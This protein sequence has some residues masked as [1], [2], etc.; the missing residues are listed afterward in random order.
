MCVLFVYLFAYGASAGEGGGSDWIIVK[1]I[2]EE[3]VVFSKSF[4][5]VERRE[6][7]FGKVI[8]MSPQPRE[9]QTKIDE[10]INLIKVAD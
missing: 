10:I 3:S 6:T 2:I 7:S 5:F 4:L 1:K 8:P 9:V